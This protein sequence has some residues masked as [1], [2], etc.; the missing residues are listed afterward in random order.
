MEKPKEHKKI[1]FN[2]DI[3]LH[4]EFK[5]LAARQNCSM[6]LLLER[7]MINYVQKYKR[8]ETDKAKLKE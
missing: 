2:V 7:L 5:V 4:T 6:S 1:I 8:E 3:D